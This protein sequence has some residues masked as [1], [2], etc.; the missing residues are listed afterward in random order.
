MKRPLFFLAFLGLTA[1]SSFGQKAAITAGG[2]ASGSG[3]SLSYSIGQP[4]YTDIA[5]ASG[6]VN[7]GV[8]QPEMNVRIAIKVLLSGPFDLS[9]GLMKDSLRMKGLIPT[10]EPYSAAPFSKPAI[11]E[12]AGESVTS[13]ILNETNQNAIVDWVYIELRAASAPATIVATKRALLQRD[14]D[15]VSNVDG[16]SPVMFARLQSGN[17]YVTVKHRNHLGVMTGT[18]IAL[19]TSAV[20]VDFTTLASVYSISGPINTPRR[21]EGGVYTLWS[22][23]A[24]FNKNT[25]YNGLS[26]DKDFILTNALGGAGFVNATLDGVYRPEDLNLDGKVR[27]NNADND[28]GVILN[29]IGVSNTN[30]IFNQHTPN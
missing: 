25:K 13:T 2:E 14:G 24:N 8:Q 9:T 5:N 17:Y 21:S 28:R 1:Y 7:Q 29:T 30:N 18:P 15:V 27:Y 11:L 10:N 22:G 16:V 3:G 20:S 6:D 26:N 19:T 4:M 12:N 23:D